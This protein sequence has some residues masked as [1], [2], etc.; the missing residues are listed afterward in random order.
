MSTFSNILPKQSKKPIPTKHVNFTQGMI[1]G[2]DEF[3][4]EFAYHSNR[5]QWM[6]RDLQGYGTVS[7][8]KVATREATDEKGI[9]ATWVDVSA[10]TAVSPRGLMIRVP[11]GQCA[12]LSDWLSKQDPAIIEKKL[13]LVT[14]N[15]PL[16]VVLSY[17]DCPTDDVPIPGEPCRNEADLTAASRLTDDF[18]LE[19][20]LDPPAQCEE[21]ALREYVQWLAGHVQLTDSATDARLDIATFQQDIRDAVQVTSPP[22]PVLDFAIASPPA[23]FTI[24]AGEACKYLHAAFL[25]WVTEYRPFWKADFSEASAGCSATAAPSEAGKAPAEDRVLLA[26]LDVPLTDG[27]VSG[28]VTVVEDK[29]PYLLHSRML[30][31]WMLCRGGKQE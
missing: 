11:R 30:Q 24:N 16:Y 15:L 6:T 1:L 18:V 19:L 5:D 31:E 8:L 28:A 9:K 13:D 17:R 27:K 3:V 12:N 29:R 23:V 22:C 2:V 20:S 4:Q 25:L 21:D 10:G 14:R 26:M 7:G